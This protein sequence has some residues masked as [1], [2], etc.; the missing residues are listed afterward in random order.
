MLR[1]QAEPNP[2]ALLAGHSLLSSEAFLSDE[3]LAESEA[4]ED[5]EGGAA[6]S[7][8]AFHSPLS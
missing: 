1:G 7:P 8:F 2:F 6:I 5:G 3:A 4:E